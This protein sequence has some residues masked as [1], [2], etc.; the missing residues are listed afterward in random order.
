VVP[1]PPANTQAPA[2]SGQAEAG[3]TLTCNT[4]TWTGNPALTIQWLRDGAPIAGA[5]GRTYVLTSADVGHD[6][7][8]RV[9]ATNAGGQVQA[10]SAPVTPTASLGSI[11]GPPP[12]VVPPAQL[13]LPPAHTCVSRRNFRIRLRAPRGEKL[14]RAIVFV[15]GKQ[16]NV[17]RGK[18]LTA[19]VD[20][21]GLPK[22]RFAVRI[23]S[24]TR[25]GKR[26]QGTRRY[27]TCAPKPK[28]QAKRRG[29]RS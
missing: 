16:V 18:R 5:T 24:V 10:T 6:I 23:I 22:G 29:S 20:L 2:I 3:Q 19:P 12:V 21:R 1:A 9:T 17:S 13:G 26:L 7:A 14:A 11:A 4:G 15:N 27:R 8:C 28:N 25:S